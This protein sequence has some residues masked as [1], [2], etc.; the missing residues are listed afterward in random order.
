MN[1]WR[2]TFPDVRIDDDVIYYVSCCV[3]QKI[4]YFI[5][6]SFVFSENNYAVNRA[7]KSKFI[8]EKFFIYFD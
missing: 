2:M 8:I 1:E 4:R 5:R 6:I 7:A 3:Y